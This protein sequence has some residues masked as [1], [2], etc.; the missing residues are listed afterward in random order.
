[1]RQRIGSLVG[2]VAAFA[3]HAGGPALA[4]GKPDCDPVPVVANRKQAELHTDFGVIRFE[5]L[6][7]PGEAPETVANFLNYV[8]RGD[9]DGMF[10]HRLAKNF[11]LQGGGFTYDPVNR[12]QAIPTDPPITNQYGFCNVRGT[13]AM[14]KV[15]AQANSATNQFFIN[16]IDNSLTLDEDQN[17]GFTVFAQVVPADMAIVDQIGALHWEY[18]PFMIDDPLADIFETLPVKHV[19]QRPPNGFGTCLKSIDPDPIM[20]PNGPGPTGDAS[21][22][23]GNQAA[24]EAAID[25]WKEQMDPRV[26]PELVMVTQVVPEPGAVALLATGA[27][28]LALRRL[29]RRR[30]LS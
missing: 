9:Y 14:A 16:L 7:E 30:R 19:L 8:R 22:C 24:L 11:V 20:P 12:Y 5:L 23:M 1:M 27:A 28:T 29:A 17:E 6:D 2:F 10:F 4:G 15:G 21:D 25:V 13:V 3:A 18:G 26:P